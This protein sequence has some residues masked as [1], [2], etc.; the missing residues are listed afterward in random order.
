MLDYNHHFWSEVEIY[1]LVVYSVFSGFTLDLYLLCTLFLLRNDLNEP[2]FHI[3]RTSLRNQQN[4]SSGH[5]CI[6]LRVSHSNKLLTGFLLLQ[7][8]PTINLGWSK[9]PMTSNQNPLRNSKSIIE[10]QIMFQLWKGK[11]IFLTMLAGV[12]LVSNKVIWNNKS[13]SWERERHEFQMWQVTQR[14]FPLQS[15]SRPQVSGTSWAVQV[16][17]TR[18]PY[19]HDSFLELFSSVVK[20]IF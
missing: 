3:V 7:L 11:P 1:K 9:W 19:D 14:K 10:H 2:F 8:R 13:K 15:V 20:K 4:T 18:K 5:V 12:V 17:L 16:I 6:S